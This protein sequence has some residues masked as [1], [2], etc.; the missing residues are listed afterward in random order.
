LAPDPAA[1]FAAIV[2][3]FDLTLVDSTEGF[4]ECHAVASR[5]V[6]LIPPDPEAVGPTIGT[7]LPAVFLLLHGEANSGLSDAYI[8]A[9]QS[10]ADEVMTGLTY[11]LNGVPEALSA[12]NASGLQLG[13][14]SQKL[15]Y[16]VED[17]LRYQGLLDL[18][19]AI[20]GGDDV[21]A[22]KPDPQGLLLALERLGV[23][24][25]S[26]LYVG[27]TIIDA[28][29]AARAGVGFIAVLTGFTEP[30]DFLP[31]RPLA[32]LDSVE[33]LPALLR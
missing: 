2:F 27:D 1:R 19:G 26:A 17:V 29:T 6:R 24:G 15:R 20:L 16:R 23:S 32:I 33:D 31:Y 13:I 30:Q 3:D 4:I 14:V 22:F 10:R 5:A 11:V 18:F 12:L 25:D 8:Q 9:Y 28:E 7:P 21:A